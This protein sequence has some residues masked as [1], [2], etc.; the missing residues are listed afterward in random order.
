MQN[1]PDELGFTKADELGFTKAECIQENY[2]VQE[3]GMLVP[4]WKHASGFWRF[5][6]SQVVVRQ[7]RL[8]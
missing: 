5:K 3:D 4:N 8:G 1:N 6:L 7:Q 2:V